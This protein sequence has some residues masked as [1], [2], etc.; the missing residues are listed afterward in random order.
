MYRTNEIAEIRNLAEQ[1]RFVTEEKNN[2]E[3]IR[4][5]KIARKNLDKLFKDVLGKIAK[6][7]KNGNYHYSYNG[8]NPWFD[9]F[10]NIWNTISYDLLKKR[11]EEEGFECYDP[12]TIGTN[13]TLRISWRNTNVRN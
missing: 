9:P 4:I 6:A 5:E 10:S 7:A 3:R 1:N 12:N 8:L 2:N 13:L 11:L